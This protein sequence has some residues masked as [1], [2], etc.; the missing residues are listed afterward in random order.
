MSTD[1]HVTASDLGDLLGISARAVSKLGARGIAVR[2]GSGRWKLRESVARYCADLR[3]QARG[4]GGTEAVA[5]AA[6][7]RGRLASAQA[8]LV[9]LR[10]AR[11]RGELLDT[12]EVEREWTDVLRVVRSGL[13]AL[14]SRVGARLSHLTPGDVAAIESEMRGVLTE[15][16]EDAHGRPP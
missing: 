7:E 10:V 2:A 4:M 14:P 11:Q 16:G 6:A 5:A 8:D 12:S 15:L 13:L 3:R 9:A 1:D